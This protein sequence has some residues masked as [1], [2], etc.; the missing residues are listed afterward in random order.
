MTRITKNI[1]LFAMI[2]LFTIM[3]L[4]S[5]TGP[6]FAEQAQDQKPS[7]KV[8]RVLFQGQ[9]WYEVRLT[10]NAGTEDILSGKV[11]ITSDTS[12]K[13]IELQRMNANSSV[14]LITTIHADSRD[15][16]SAAV[17][18]VNK[19]QGPSVS[20]IGS[21]PVIGGENGEYW[22]QFRV[23]AGDDNVSKVHLNIQS[24]RDAIKI[25]ASGNNIS[26][27]SGFIG[28]HTYAITTV[29]L[30]ADDPTSIKASILDYQIN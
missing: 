7:A 1:G 25:V 24:D 10:V 16:I 14:D 28:A 27:N 30:K 11:S 23:Y 8:D 2:P 18:Q 3:L 21:T 19:R 6:S 5:Y 13:E 22:A 17:T 15:S 4:A 12:S 26:R 29:K 9:G 20:Y